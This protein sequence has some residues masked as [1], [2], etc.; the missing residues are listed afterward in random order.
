MA[1][2]PFE[3]RRPRRENKNEKDVVE[4]AEYYGWMGFKVVS[5]AFNGMPDR[6]FVREGEFVLVE[7]KQEGK[8][9]TKLQHVRAR[10]LREK[11][12]KVYWLDSPEGAHAI[13]RR[14]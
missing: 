1:K 4:I 8:E 7:V 14:D 5:P 9:P 13:F 11:G 2:D 6:G 10:Q 12:I 3:T